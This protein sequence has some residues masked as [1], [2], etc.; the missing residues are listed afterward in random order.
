VVKLEEITRIPRV[1]GA[2]LAT[3]D[4]FIVE[5]QFTV[6]Y[7]AE[8]SAAMAAQIINVTMRSLTA[9]NASVV[10]YTHTSVFFIKKVEEGVFFVICQRDAN[11]GLIKIKVD[12]IQ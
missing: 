9:Q 11:L 8:K 3:D 7:D 10:L 5:S 2:G 12:R 4:G 1:L 6:G